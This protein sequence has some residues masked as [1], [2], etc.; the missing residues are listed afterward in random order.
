MIEK[1]GFADLDLE[2]LERLRVELDEQIEYK[3][4]ERLRK[5]RDQ[6]Q[7]IAEGHG[8]TVAELM[9][10]QLPKVKAP[11]AKP[12]PRP[13][14]Y[15]NPDNHEETWVGMGHKPKWLKAKLERGADLEDFR[16]AGT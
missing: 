5:A 1:K 7:S 4:D 9:G 16:I 2:A 8:T 6:I 10:Y 13:I 11:R 14:K 12:E 3:R 15:R